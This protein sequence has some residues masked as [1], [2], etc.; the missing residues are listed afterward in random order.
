MSPEL[1]NRLAN[2]FP[3]LFKGKSKQNTESLMCYGCDHG[4]G[5]FNIIHSMCHAIENHLKR[6]D[7][8][9]DYEFFQIKE[10]FGAL[11]VYDNGHDEYIKGVIRMAENMSSV[12]CEVTG[13]PGRL[14]TSGHWYRTLCDEQAEK[15]GYAPAGKKED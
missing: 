8:R 3:E 15:D 11:R 13:K 2:E 9:P 5:W 14:C 6:M 4:D 10:K 1:E 12:T 7:S